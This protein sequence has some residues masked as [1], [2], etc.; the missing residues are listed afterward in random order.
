TRPTLFPYTTLFRSDTNLPG[1]GGGAVGDGTTN[2]ASV[3]LNLT[4]PIY[5]GG[6]VS[7]QVRQSKESLGQARIEVDVARDSV[8]RAVTA[9]W[10]QYVAAR[11]VVAANREL[12]SAAQLALSGVIEERDVGQRTTLNVLEAQ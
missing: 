2:S 6:R 1:V 11:E 10:T 9:A 12:V 8:R 3:G 4:I 7:A 5:Q